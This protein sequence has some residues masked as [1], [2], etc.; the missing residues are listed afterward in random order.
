[1][2]KVMKFFLLLTIIA[3][4][5]ACSN[6]STQSDFD[7]TD[8]QRPIEQPD[9]DPNPPGGS[10]ATVITISGFSGNR[11]LTDGPADQAEFGFPRDLLMDDEWNLYISDSGNR[12]IRMMTPD[13]VVTTFA[14]TGEFGNEDGPRN[15]A[16]LGSPNQM[17]WHENGD[18]Y[19]TDRT[20]HFVRKISSDGIVSTIAGTGARSS[21]DG[22]V[23][24]AT[25]ELPNGIVIDAD[26]NIYVSD[27]GG[28]TIRMI[29]PDGNVVTVAGSGEFGFAEGNARN[30]AFRWPGSMIMDG[31][32]NII[33][34]DIRN[35]MIRKLA[36]N[37]DVMVIA[38]TGER[39]FA[40]GEALQAQ[41]NDPGALLLADNGSIY[42][43]DIRN[44]R[45]RKISADGVVTTIAGTGEEGFTDGPALEAT[46]NAPFGLAFDQDGNLFV[47]DLENNRIRKIIFE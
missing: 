39:G 3:M 44:H 9:D 6:N 29:T 43:A 5:S 41:F 2:R 31:E 10:A 40:D 36:P 30:A 24:R 37:G 25:F 22:P 47:S 12:A 26:G 38:G 27:T 8:P 18:M 14:G 15:E 21:V 34:S 11:T 45:I 20:T 32:G 23:D 4:Y 19:F 42:V 46:F 7:D 1:M 17:V 16:T 33:L 28:N 35:H 13:G